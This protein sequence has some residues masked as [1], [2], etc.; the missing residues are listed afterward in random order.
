LPSS[1]PS[2]LRRLP[3]QSCNHHRRYSW[4]LR[5]LIVRNICAL[6]ESISINS[7]FYYPG[8]YDVPSIGFIRHVHASYPV[9]I[10]IVP[11]VR[12]LFIRASRIE[13]VALL[14][15]PSMIFDFVRHDEM[16]T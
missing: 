5:Q 14:R 7:V 8:S 1:L 15:S 6:D 10:L 9:W 2:P 4:G 3:D 16:W 12:L 13:M 11:F